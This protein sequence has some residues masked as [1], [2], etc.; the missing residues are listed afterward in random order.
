LTNELR[1]EST[2]VKQ[3]IAATR[4]EERIP[5]AMSPLVVEP[6]PK[7]EIKSS[8]KQRPKREDRITAWLTPEER[9]NWALLADAK[10]NTDST[11][12]RKV[13]VDFM[14]AN[15]GLIEQARKFREGLNQAA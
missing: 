6:A 2:D 13:L 15:A 8:V 3:D 14:K 10:G 4:A 1:P 11:L 7:A 5:A 9:A 12:A